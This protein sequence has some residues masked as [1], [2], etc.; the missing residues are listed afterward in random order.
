M[1]TEAG[2]VGE[3]WAGPQMR[4]FKDFYQFVAPTR[5]VAGRGLI[6]G[7]GF[8]FS[9]EGAKRVAI[10]TDEV[11]RGTGLIDK[12]EAGVTD[13]G[14]EVAGVFDGVPQDSDSAAVTGAAEA[15]REHGADAILAVGGGSVMDT[16]KAANV[17]FTHGGEP[18]EWEGYFG[19]PRDDD[20]L[21]R[22]FD[23][24]PLACLP[25]TAGTGSEVSFAAVIKDRDD[26]ELVR[27]SLEDVVSGG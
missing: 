17:I 16:A 9:K 21:G 4:G 1:A 14:L 15:A 2:T 3:A 27:E 8:E 12:V 24:A 19:L 13:G 22:P 25:T 20:G 10:I 11:I 26:L 7:L 23:L 5:V 6:E 18:R